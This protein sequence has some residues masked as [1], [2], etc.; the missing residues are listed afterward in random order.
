M[1]KTHMF[2]ICPDCR[3]VVD[4]G[5]ICICKPKADKILFNLTKKIMSED[6]DSV[7]LSFLGDSIAKDPQYKTIT[8]EQY[9]RLKLAAMVQKHLEGIMGGV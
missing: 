2:S 1:Y 8:H 4:F 7:P 6:L 3:R 5:N 9:V